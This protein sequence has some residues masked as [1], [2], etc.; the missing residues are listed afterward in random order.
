MRVRQTGGLGEVIA[1]GGCVLR[2]NDP[3]TPT[4]PTP[5][6]CLIVFSEGGSN[7]LEELRR[8]DFWRQAA[9]CSWFKLMALRTCASNGERASV[10]E[11]A[12]VR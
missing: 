2:R 7:P 5:K 8:E 10:S 6:A 3:V 9:V 12:V 1:D 4:T 11:G